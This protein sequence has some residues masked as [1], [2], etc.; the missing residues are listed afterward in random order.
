MVNCLASKIA[1]LRQK[2]QIEFFQ[3]RHLQQ[4][5]QIEHEGVSIEATSLQNTRSAMIV[6]SSSD[7]YRSPTNRH[8]DRI[9]TIA[10]TDRSREDR[11]LQQQ[12]TI[13]THQHA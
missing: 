2:S 10:I 5:F 6:Y 12:I 11:Q 7:Y 3:N 9:A 4:R 1:I 13:T 8:N